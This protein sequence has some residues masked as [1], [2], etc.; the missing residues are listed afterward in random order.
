LLAGVTIYGIQDPLRVF[1]IDPNTGWRLAWWKDAIEATVQNGGIGVGFGTE[2]LR[3]DYGALLERD[4]YREEG[5]TFLLV[6][7]HSAFFDTLFR[8]GLVGVFLF[9]LVLVRCIPTAN[10]PP[11]A[12]AH[13]CSI[14]AIMILC[15][16]SNLGLQSPMYSIGIAVCIGFLQAERHKA[17]VSAAARASDRADDAARYDASLAPRSVRNRYR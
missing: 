9:L 16:H 10:I 2:S 8:T 5:G 13:C 11:L 12:R 15:L 14:F 17:S 6:G 1:E 3:N 7:T 4:S